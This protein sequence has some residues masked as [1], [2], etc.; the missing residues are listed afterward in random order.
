MTRNGNSAIDVELQNMGDP[1]LK[2]ADLEDARKE[3]IALSGVPAPYLGYNEVIELRD[4]LSHIN[5]TF[6]TTVIEYQYVFN[7]GINQ[8]IDKICMECGLE[9]KNSDYK[10]LALIPPIIL[11][12]QLL[13]STVS[14]VNNVINSL[15]GMQIASD[16]YYLLK[17]YIPHMDWDAFKQASDL[18]SMEKETKDGMKNTV[19]ND[20]G[21]GM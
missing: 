6:A 2:V 18:Y 20:P 15:N 8:L 19:A 3:L 21:E 5:I 12:L 14:S 17:Q 16:P 10:E 11:I 9:Y 7:K 13:E 1:S 4:Q